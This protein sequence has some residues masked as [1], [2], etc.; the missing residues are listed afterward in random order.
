MIT[1]KTT[2]FQNFLQVKPRSGYTNKLSPLES[3]VQQVKQITL[4]FE[5]NKLLKEME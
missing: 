2:D 5:K 1:R 4:K 3:E